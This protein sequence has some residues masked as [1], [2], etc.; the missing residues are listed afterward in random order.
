MK[1][2]EIPG[3][4]GNSQKRNRVGRG[5]ATGNGKTSGR[6]MKGQKARSGGYHKVG[7]EG[8]QM[9]MQR[10][11]PKRGFKNFSQKRFDVVNVGQLESRFEAG[12]EV[13][14]DS[15]RAKGLA[16][17]QIADG[18]KL[19]SEGEISK[20]LTVRVDKASA[21][22]IAKIEAAGGKVEVTM[23]VAAAEV[24]A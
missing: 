21:A 11:L 1:L 9:P 24:E 17:K 16:P 10:R 5:A 18:I 3:V 13:T 20:A 22:A 19:L 7:F 23:P 6:G 4:P 14:I 8:G 2:N 15:L 12:E